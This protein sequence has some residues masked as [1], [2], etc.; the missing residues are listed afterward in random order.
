MTI[1]QKLTAAEKI[2][3][4]LDQLANPN[5]DAGPLE[6]AFASL[7]ITLDHAL[8]GALEDLQDEGE[9]DTIILVLARWFATHRSDTAPTRIVV[10]ELPNRRDLPPATLLHQLE[11]AQG[12]PAPDGFPLGK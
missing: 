4:T 8:P 3:N 12:V 2:M 5:D 7:A 9:L 11:L 10:V 1:E 6:L